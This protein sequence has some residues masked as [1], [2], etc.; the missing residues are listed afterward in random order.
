MAR[1]VAAIK[2]KIS[3]TKEEERHNKSISIKGARDAKDNGGHGGTILSEVNRTQK[4]G[5]HRAE[6]TEYR[7][8]RIYIYRIYRIYCIQY[9]EYT[10]YIVYVSNSPKTGLNNFQCSPYGI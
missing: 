9:E 7:I 3:T 8:Y 2:Y 5:Q 10:A 4:P 1:S 6:Y